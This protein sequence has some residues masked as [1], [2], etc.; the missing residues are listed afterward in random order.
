MEKKEKRKK[1]SVPDDQFEIKVEFERGEGDPAR[2]FRAM[3]GL[4]ESVQIFDQH[5]AAIVS[6]KIQTKLILQDIK[7]G[8]LISV[9]KT[10][11][12]DIPDDILKTGEVKKILGHFY[13]KG[14]H[15][16]LDWCSERKEI[17][18]RDDVK[19]LEGKLLKLAEQTNIKHI[20]AYVPIETVA[21]LSDIRSV[22]NA[23]T[24]LE[25]KDSAIL[26]SKEASS[27]F[28]KNLVIPE[29]IVRELMT[30]ET[31]VSEG[32]KIFKVKK[33]DYLGDSQWAFKYSNHIIFAKILCEQWL[34]NFQL[35]VIK[36]HPGDSL[37]TKVKEETLYGYNNEIVQ[38]NYEIIEV[39]EIIQA[40]KAIQGDLF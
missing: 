39:I 28:N 21:L 8:S 19:E 40:Q 23:L 24:N 26:I 20:P 37:R 22:N 2:I 34:H 13:C 6:T 17:K 15:V 29:D 31:I 3:S 30:K 9:F 10:I 7:A 32:E 36:V 27:H 35:G 18:N 4:I 1:K 5:L 14:K 12:K 25:E 33:P 38:I 11:I 16:F